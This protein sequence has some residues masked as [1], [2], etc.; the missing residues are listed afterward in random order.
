MDFDSFLAPPRWKILEII[1]KK[2]SSPIE[3][4]DELKTSVAYVSQQLKLLEAGN[5]IEKQKTGSAE[6]GKPRTLF[7]PSKKFA[8]I[9]LLT[10]NFTGKKMIDID[11]H[12]ETILKIWFSDHPES[13]HIEKLYWKLEDDLKD[14]SAIIMTGK[15]NMELMIISDSKKIKSKVESYIGEIGNKIDCRVISSQSAE[16]TE[17]S[18]FLHKHPSFNENHLKGGKTK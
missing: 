11:S 16:S 2:P 12:Y 13:Y 7:S 15:Q 6:K 3:I 10:K 18:I 5:L 17:N 9:T 1:T 8:H 14:I 4:A